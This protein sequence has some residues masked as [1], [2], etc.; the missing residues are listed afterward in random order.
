MPSFHAG[1]P[2]L[3]HWGD[4]VVEI[5]DHDVLARDPG[6]RLAAGEVTPCASTATSFPVIFFPPLVV[7]SSADASRDREQKRSAWRWKSHG[8]N[9]KWFLMQ[10]GEMGEAGKG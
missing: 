4:R 9:P 10:S 8:R 6:L 5:D 7:M 2:I 3:G 1:L